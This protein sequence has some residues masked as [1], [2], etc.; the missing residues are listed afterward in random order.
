MSVKVRKYVHVNADTG[1]RFD[2]WEVDIRFKWPDGSMFRRRL[3]APD[4]VNTK[5]NA[6]R[7]G[8]NEERVLYAAGKTSPIAK[9]KRT[10]DAPSNA[11][12]EKEVPTLEKFAPRFIK[13]Y[14]RAEKQKASTIATK[15]RILRLHLL[16]LLGSKR[17]DQITDVDVQ[18]VKASL[19]TH[20]RKT[21]NNVVNILSKLLNVA[22]EWKVIP[23]RSCTIK[24]LKVNLS[25]PRFYEYDEYARLVDAARD[26]DRQVLLM[27]LLGGDAGLRRGEIIALRWR[28]VDLRRKQLTIEQS[29]WQ[30]VVDVPKSGRGRIVPMTTAL[31]KE[32]AAHRHLRSQNVLCL[33][34]G[35]P[36]DENTLQEW[37][38]QAT[39][40]AGLPATRSL[41]IL[42]HTFC[43]H[44]AM[45]GA[46]AKAIQ[47]LAGHGSLAMTLRYMH[48]AKGETDR[49][50]RLL[51]HRESGERVENES[52]EAAQ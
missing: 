47:D 38:E 15:E 14:A 52:S 29:S 21:L 11:P 1:A 26:I 33:D 35:R 4:R 30:G 5:T 10:K 23:H 6:Q 7:W 28:D 32:L 43:S 36:T 17:L 50:I 12:N 49:A 37:I 40:G 18:K 46:P 41:H 44:L 42:R 22:V 51:D 16:P 39:K 45:K 48:L 25:T 2:G 24:L 3:K 27:T 8:E 9:S 19:T 31:A 13:D 34:E 20:S